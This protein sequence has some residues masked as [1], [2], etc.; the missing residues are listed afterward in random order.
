M[1]KRFKVQDLRLKNIGIL[2]AMVGLVL[3]LGGCDPKKEHLLSR[4]TSCLDF[5][6][7]GQCKRQRVTEVWRYSDDSIR[8]E[9]KTIYL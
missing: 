5:D 4:T 3:I 6:S 1:R 9:E 2:V 7:S 8:T